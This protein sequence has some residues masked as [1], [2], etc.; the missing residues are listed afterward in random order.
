[1]KH[2]QLHNSVIADS[3]TPEAWFVRGVACM[4]RSDYSAAERCF[5]LTLLLAPESPET[6]LNL[7][8]ALDKLGRDEEALSCY[9]AVLAF[10]PGN[11]KARY[12]RGIHL[13]RAGNLAA[14]FTDYEARFA[15]MQNAD[16]RR[17]EQPRWDGSPLNGRSI[18][19]YG[20]QGLGDTL[21]FCRYIPLIA[22]LGGR[23]LLEVQQPLVSLLATLAGV[24]QVV[25]K[26]GQP[27]L[28]A[29]HIPLLSLPHLF[30]TT[31]ATVPA[32]IPYLVPDSSKVVLWRQLLADDQ[33]YR[34][35]VVWSGSAANPM[36]RER[37]CPLSE[38]APLFTL[39][40]C[41]CYSLQVGSAAV[42]I[43]TL[44]HGACLNDLTSHL[45]DFSDTAALVANLDLVITVD[46]AVAHLAGALGKPVWLLLAYRPDWRWMLGRNDS[47]WYPAMRLFRQ[48]CPGDWAAAVQ[49]MVQLLPEQRSGHSK[50]P[51]ASDEAYGNI[52]R[53]ALVAIDNNECDTAISRLESLAVRLPDDPAVWFHLGRAYALKKRFN[54]AEHCYRQSLLHDSESPAIWYG[55]GRVCLKQNK[56]PEA[57]K[58]LR[59]AHTLNPGSIDILLD[60]GAALV[61]LDNIPE[62]FACCRKILDINPDSAEATYNMAYLQLRRGDY[63]TGF[64]NFEARFRMK[65]Q[66]ADTREY[67]QPRWDGS[68][69][70]GRS[71][72]VYGEQGMGDVIQFARYIPLLAERGGGVV[73][74]VDP[75]LLPLFARF[76]GVTKCVAKSATPP[77]TDV[78]I[79]LLS[80][81]YLFGTTYETVPSR[82]P[83]IVADE[84]KVAR[85]KPLLADGAKLK[86]GL[87]W[88]GNPLNSRDNERSCPLAA[89]SPL[90]VLPHITFYSLQ[91][92]AAAKEAAS[93]PAGMELVDFSPALNDFTETS[94]L[95]ANLDL[96]ISVDTAVAHLAGAMGKPVWVLL[97]ENGDWRWL[98]GRSDTPWYPGMQ[99]F[100]QERQGGWNW[101]LQQ[102]K[103]ALEKLL[104]VKNGQTVPF[105]IE[106]AYANGAKFKAAGDLVG[107]ESCFRQITLHQPD[108]PDPQHSLG[109]VLQLQGRLEEAIEHYHSAINHDP[110]FVKAHYNLAHALQALGLYQDA[111]AAVR[112]TLQYAPA[113]ADAHWLLGMLLLQNG[114]FQ[115]GWSEYEW[116]WKAHGFTSRIPDLGRPQWDGSSLAG[117]ILLIHME[118]GRGDMIQFIRYA[119]LVTA[120]G[121]EVVACALPELVS[122]LETVKGISRVVD[123]NG[124]LPPFDVHIPVQ[125]LPHLF[126]TVLSSVPA[127]VPYLYPAPES[128]AAW[129][130][131]LAGDRQGFRI[132][133]VWAGNEQ[134]NADRSCPLEN[135][136]P[137]FSLP[138]TVF[139]SLQI[140]KQENYPLHSAYRDLLLDHTGNIRDFADTAAL[141]VNLDLIISIDTASAH[142][143][144][145]LGKPV[146]TLLPYV[147]DWR[148]L[149]SRED[150]PWYPSMRLF[151]QEMRGDW[152]GAIAR[153]LQA[154]A[155]IL[156][157]GSS[158]QQLGFTLL[159]SGDTV[160]AERAFAAAIATSPDDA[161]AYCHRGVAL[162]AL[163]RCEEAVLCY[164][165]ALSRKPDFMQALFNL[166]NSC[167]SLGKLDKARFCYEQVIELVPNFVPAYLALGEIFKTR[168]D[169]EKARSC[170][171]RAADIDPACADAF[172]GIAE[173]CQAEER[174]EEA[175]A[176]YKSTLAIVPDRVSALNMLGAVYQCQEMLEEASCYYRC[177]LQIDPRRPTVLNNLGVVLTSQGQLDEAVTVLR[178]L[179]EIDPD[180]AEGH[181]NLAVALLAAGSYRDG[182]REFEWRFKKSNPV[183]ERPF[184]APR[185]DG[186][187]LHGKTVLLHAE[188]GFGDT[189]QFVRYVS[190]VAGRG[191][192]VIVECQVPALKEL[193][194]SVAGVTAVVAAGEPLPP[195]DCH[196]PLMSLPLVFG[197]TPET[198]PA[199]IPYLSAP[200]AKVGA[201]RQR[202]GTSGKMRVG[203][204]WFAKQS[205]ILNRKRSCPLEMFAPLWQVPDVEFYTLQIGVGTDQLAEFSAVY[206]IIDF[207]PHIHD[208]ADTAAFMA[209]L[210][211]VITIDTAVAHLAGAVGART[212][213]V[214][215][216]VAEWRWLCAR[217]DSPWYPTMRLFRQPSPGDW[218][219][220]MDAVAVAL[221]AAAVEVTSKASVKPVYTKLRVGLAW[222]GRQDNPLNIKRS[223]PFAALE[224][225]LKLKEIT[226]VALQL[227]STENTAAEMIDITAQIRDFE[228]TAAL[229]ANLDLVISIDTSVAHLAAAT[230]RPTW[231]LLSHVADWRWSVGREKSPWYPAVSLFR[232]PDFG[233]WDSVIREVAQRLVQLSDRPQ[234]LQ[235]CRV[236]VIIRSGSSVDRETLESL[237]EA[238][239]EA[240]QLHAA[241]PEAQLD[242]GASLALLGRHEEAVAAFRRVLTLDPGH[243]TAHLNLAYSLLALGEY[244]EG[245]RHFEWRLQRLGPGQLPPWPLLQRHEL[246]THKKGTS[247]LVHCEQGFGDTIQF[248]RYLPLLAAAGYRVV[249]SCQPPLATLVG[250][251][252]GVSQV[253]PHGAPLPVSDLQVLLLTLPTLFDTT[254]VTIPADI[255]YLK[256]A[257]EK[258]E[259][260]KSRLD[261]KISTSENISKV[262]CSDDE[263]LIKR[264]KRNR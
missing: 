213:V 252:H 190:M 147:A 155:T 204:V 260:W 122:L 99:L 58:C 242:V 47:P 21:Q 115:S 253:I 258:V 128:V 110:G 25:A 234:E 179:L 168:R 137:L 237:L 193:L 15:A 221:R 224:P 34:I 96:V 254:P 154:L 109:V 211:L 202:V 7:G 89:F 24:E 57:E 255:P 236:P 171:Q 157:G 250:S 218:S 75:P 35:G 67:L 186:S 153:L 142:L 5:R 185:W 182:W 73:F 3:D 49:K 118:Q 143:A 243:V 220:L 2:K 231:L 17:Y 262:L 181:W 94:A 45:T 38:L 197:T 247:L 134:P 80:L 56:Y 77:L 63:R 13:L 32:P 241:S 95:I 119:S 93:P 112:T 232:Q 257:K 180:Y 8:Y 216:H 97:S 249:V 14:G 36:D 103:M 215:P 166:G 132:G 42:E 106:A 85:W 125:S 105:D 139:Y 10:S 116:R 189:I 183:P 88:R 199:Q 172:Q 203:L 90:A 16:N 138:N 176:A 170:Y 100:C 130:G 208:F 205:Q 29:C 148:W 159:N 129:S 217:S 120:A 121:G 107:A 127:N 60:L 114:D 37:S 145:A 214:L 209:N 195:F 146:W 65:N 187:A 245:W 140:G 68:A 264:R 144:G 11:A 261:Q 27:P 136:A 235:S 152:S 82:I 233:D 227:D 222:S 66:Q 219:S 192:R 33:L 191:G 23:V 225:L 19:V 64:A 92:G 12:N 164:H 83:Y 50:K 18:L 69:L 223:C 251:I 44:P 39:P 43:A 175:I 150:S 79:Q 161:E 123:R 117:K 111:L 98:Q 194:L 113:D 206:K 86:I 238:N 4:E 167:I 6:L 84:V 54:A 40:G 174:Y 30:G 76:P 87:V 101:V 26:S 178:H 46:T 31:L 229:M 81:P 201:W 173:V 51:E 151:R 210:D 226:F 248:V 156:P 48:P 207:T 22:E 102:V 61:Q 9:A 160:A 108:L 184:A 62:A 141:M 131:K 133:L 256:P 149:L 74:E 41:S 263:K 198:I 165:E 55:L 244:P 1:M 230:G 196:I 70:N 239:Q 28:T 52:F 212:W 200:A 72:L 162:D 259:L 126:G 188:Q 53:E 228:D 177:A 71:I 20:E 59:R 104:A 169:F 163:G 78:Y 91:V 240:L 158:L 246:G 124:P 135:F